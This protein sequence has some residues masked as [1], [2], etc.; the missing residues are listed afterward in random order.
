[1]CEGIVRSLV[2]AAGALAAT[3]AG[4]AP[5]QPSSFMV[6]RGP[7]AVFEGLRATI[8]CLDIAIARRFNYDGHAVLQYRFA[9]RCN[10]PIR[11]DL[12]GVAV[13]GQFA[14]GSQL[15][16]RPYDPAGELQPARLDGRFTGREAI[17]YPLPG[18]LL[19]V[20]VDASTIVRSTRTSRAHWLCFGGN[21]DPD[22]IA[23]AEASP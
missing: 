5:Y 6:G 22:S 8:D 10:R 2:L 15:P 21:A 11:V 12:G 19:Q 23:A 20:C 17:A 9:N 4:C 13:V 16:L 3:V 7:G 1:L 18:K 14:D